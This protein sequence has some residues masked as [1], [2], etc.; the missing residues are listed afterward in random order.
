[1]SD[2]AGHAADKKADEPDTKSIELEAERARLV[3]RLRAD[4]EQL[5]ENQTD[6]DDLVHNVED[7]PD[8]D[9]T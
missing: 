7:A 5:A 9:Q 1:M 8:D 6:P 3:K 2:T 4:R